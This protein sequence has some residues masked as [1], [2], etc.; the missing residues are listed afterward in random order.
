MLIA[1]DKTFDGLDLILGETAEVSGRLYKKSLDGSGGECYSL[2]MRY[3]GLSALDGGNAS[4]AVDFFREAVMVDA[5]G[6]PSTSLEYIGSVHDLGRALHACG[7]FKEAC[8]VLGDA[9]HSL[10]VLYAETHNCHRELALL[11]LD[12]GMSLRESGDAPAACTP[13]R[14]SIPYFRQL[15]HDSPGVPEFSD[16]LAQSLHEYGRA[17]CDTSHVSEAC[18]FLEEAASV[19]QKLQEDSVDSQPDTTAFYAF[20]HGFTLHEC[21]KNDRA[22]SVIADAITLQR[23]LASPKALIQRTNLARFLEHL[24]RVYCEEGRFQEALE[25]LAEAATLLDEACDE[26]GDE[27]G[28][29]VLRDDLMGFK[30]RLAD[31][32]VHLEEWADATDLHTDMQ[33]VLASKYKENPKKY[34]ELFAM[35]LYIK[36]RILQS[37]GLLEAARWEATTARLLPAYRRSRY[38]GLKAELESFLSYISQESPRTSRSIGLD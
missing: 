3:R 4:D 25:P 27:I 20:M 38:P 2:I 29:Y 5:V 24:G 28:V 34:G 26:M 15:H 6:D 17:L 11:L 14:R 10:D 35:N 12:Y 31:S 21:R 18:S 22:L 33:P 7:R 32:L 13:L 36:A 30:T 8:D 19:R 1:L 16:R 9:A 37:D 23:P